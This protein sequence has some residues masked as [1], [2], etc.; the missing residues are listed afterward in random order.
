MN[1]CS[2]HILHL[3]I[4]NSIVTY[5]NP[6]EKHCVIIITTEHNYACTYI[7]FKIHMHIRNIKLNL[8][9]VLFLIDHSIKKWMH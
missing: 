7:A 2:K 8:H 9:L 4:L 3:S 5:I 1:A 6:M